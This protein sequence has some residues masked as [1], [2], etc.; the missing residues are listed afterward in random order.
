[1]ENFLP[2]L[3]GATDQ[4]G[5]QALGMTSTKRQ[6]LNNKRNNEGIPH[7]ERKMGKTPTKTR[8]FLPW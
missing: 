5:I 8:N 6:A 1:M 2:Y 7:E 4:I 3:V